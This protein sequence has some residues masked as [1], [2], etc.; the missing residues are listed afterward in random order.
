MLKGLYEVHLPVH[1]LQRSIEFYRNLG[2]QLAYEY[3]D[4]AFL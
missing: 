4:I 2:L 3:E 1:D